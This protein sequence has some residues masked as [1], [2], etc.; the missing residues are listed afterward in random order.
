MSKKTELKFEEVYSLLNAATAV[1]LDADHLIYPEMI[2]DADEPVFMKLNVDDERELEF[3]TEDNQI[4]PVFNEGE[5]LSLNA[6]K[7]NGDKV[8]Y[9]VRLLHVKKIELPDA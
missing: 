8:P 3:F 2:D 5:G 9:E 6:R 1:T 4:V 7:R